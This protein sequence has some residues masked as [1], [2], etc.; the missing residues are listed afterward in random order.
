MRQHVLGILYTVFVRNFLRLI[1][2]VK[3]YNAQ[4]L[5][6]SPQYII[7]SNHNSHLDTMALLAALEYKRISRT[8]PVAAGDYFGKSRRRAFLTRYFVNAVLIPR[9]L[10]RG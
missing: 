1:V 7:V 10:K 8:H 5:T 6:K 2:G 3:Y 9:K 4:V